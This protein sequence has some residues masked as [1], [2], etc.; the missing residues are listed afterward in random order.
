M[1]THLHTL[2]LFIWFSL[3]ILCQV[4]TGNDKIVS[5]ESIDGTTIVD[6]AGLI[7]TVRQVPGLVLID[8]R[9][10]ADRKEGFI[11]GSVSLPDTETNCESLAEIVP[12]R[13]TPVLFY[14]NGINCGRSAT[15]ASIAVDCGYTNV[16]W[17]RNGME[18]WLEQEFPLVQ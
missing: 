9:I 15:T 12:T 17:F 14:C 7:E 1:P 4:A 3:T 13:T 16:Y 18:E 2:L 8:S 11:E 5:P 10:K 6:A